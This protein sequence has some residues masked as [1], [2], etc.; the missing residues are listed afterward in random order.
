VLITDP[1]KIKPALPYVYR[2][3]ID[4]RFCSRSIVT[5]VVKVLYFQ[6]QCKIQVGG[7]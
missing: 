1:F 4:V 3:D 6:L 7:T 5:I 2:T